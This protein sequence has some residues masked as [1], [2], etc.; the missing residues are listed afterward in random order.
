MR[1][2]EKKKRYLTGGCATTS[3]GKMKEKIE[4][5]WGGKGDNRVELEVVLRNFW[6]GSMLSCW[7]YKT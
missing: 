2:F 4:E 1:W 7:W 6:R 5:S 3:I